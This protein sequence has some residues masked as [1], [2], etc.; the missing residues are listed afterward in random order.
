MG[1]LEEAAG[2]LPVTLRHSNRR[3]CLCRLSSYNRAAGVREEA[4]GAWQPV[5]DPGMGEVGGDVEEEAG[6]YRHPRLPLR[7]I[8]LKR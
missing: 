1:V 2:G 3:R 7:L 5:V 4:G 8:R 6:A